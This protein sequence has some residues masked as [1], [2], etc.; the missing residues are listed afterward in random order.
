MIKIFKKIK[1]WFNEDKSHNLPKAT[2]EEIKSRIESVYP[3]G[4]YE[5]MIK[6][7]PTVVTL[8]SDKFATRDDDILLLFTFWELE[9]GGEFNTYAEFKSLLMS[10]NLAIPDTITRTR[11][12]LQADHK[13]LRGNLYDVRKKAE[14]LVTSQMRFDFE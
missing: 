6:I 11:R 12:K 7:K 14:K 1:K 13:E 2:Q 3:V 8:L 10:G 4:F 9:N 5:K